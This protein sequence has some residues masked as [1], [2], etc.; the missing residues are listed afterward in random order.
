MLLPWHIKK[1][2]AWPFCQKCRWQVTP[3]DTYTFDLTQSGMTMPLSRHSVRTYWETSSHTINQ[4]TLSQSCKLAK[5]PWTDPGL[6]SGI[7]VHELISTV[8][9]KKTAQMENELSNI[10][11]ESLQARKKPSPPKQFSL[12][13]KIHHTHIW[14]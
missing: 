11:P 3:K 13:L 6:K 10:L 14:L 4:G 1:K 9:K 2:K 8:K 7:S 5:P 12:M